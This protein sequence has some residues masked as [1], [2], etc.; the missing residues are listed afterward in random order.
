MNTTQKFARH[1]S[2]HNE[3]GY[4]Y[5]PHEAAMEQEARAKAEARIQH[6]IE[7]IGQY[8][9]AWGV[10]V[11]KY[12]KAGK[13]NMLDMPKIEKEAGVNHLEIQE[14]KRRMAK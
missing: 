5:N 3:S 8:R 12:S 11:A 7:N 1:A 2:I 10:A 13:I 9:A 14:V 6:I 4:G